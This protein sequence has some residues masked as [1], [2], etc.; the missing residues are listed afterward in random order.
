MSRF[1]F[2]VFLLCLL[3]MECMLKFTFSFLTLSL[4]YRYVSIYL[5]STYISVAMSKYNTRI[6]YVSILYFSVL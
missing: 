2:S 5:L 6:M 3:T 1:S 4:P